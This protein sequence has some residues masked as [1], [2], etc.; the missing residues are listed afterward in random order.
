MSR[1]RLSP[2]VVSQPET[3]LSPAAVSQYLGDASQRELDA[4]RTALDKRLAALEAA[5]ANPDESE[6]L[7]SLVIELGRVATA[8]ADATATRVCLQARLEAQEQV[9]AAQTDAEQQ[10]QTE[11]SAAA[12]LRS[13]QAPACACSPALWRTASDDA[14][15]DSSAKL[16]YS[17]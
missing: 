17:T 10:L 4:L 1:H 9:A 7:E 2:A 15:D 3:G 8:E 14:N 13:S 6:A 12:A 5:L 16:A 11:R